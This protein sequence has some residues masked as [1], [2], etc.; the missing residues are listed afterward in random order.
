MRDHTYKHK[1]A[2]SPGCMADEWDEADQQRMC[3]K[4]FDRNSE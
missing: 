4:L 3:E 2:E 1:E